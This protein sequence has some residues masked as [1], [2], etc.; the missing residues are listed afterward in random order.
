MT[1]S[2][3]NQTVSSITI[4]DGG[5]GYLKAP[6]VQIFNSDLD[7]YGSAVPASG[8]GLLLEPQGAP[9]IW[10][11]T[12]CPTDPIAVWSPTTSAVLICRY[13]D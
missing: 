2:V 4:D 10:N 8:S 11:G 7:P 12:I 1:G 13:L 6:Y 3:P 9:L 5:A